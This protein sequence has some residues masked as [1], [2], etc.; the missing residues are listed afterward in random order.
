MEE[1]KSNLWN[2]IVNKS[3][4]LLNRF[5]TFDKSS[6]AEGSQY[7][8]VI[9]DDKTNAFFDNGVPMFVVSYDGEK[10]LGEIGPIKDYRPNYV[11][12]RMRSWQAYHESDIAQTVL[13]KHTIWII[14]S[15]LKLQADPVKKVLE[16]EN[17]DLDTEEF[18]E[19]AEARFRTYAYSRC[20]DYSNMSNLQM[21]ANE[22][23]KNCVIGGDVL[24]ILRYIENEIKFQLIDGANV[25]SPFGIDEL[26]LI[27][28]RGNTIKHGIEL[29]P[30]GTHVAYYVRKAGTFID[31]ERV[32]ARGDSYGRMMAYMVYGSKYR[33]DYHR[34]MPLISVIL[35]TIKKLER[36]K[37]ATIGSAEERQKIVYSIEH[38]RDSNGENPLNRQLS[39]SFDYN[40]GNLNSDL[41][42]TI[43][44]NNLANTIS[45]SVNK[46]TYNMPI[47]SQLKALE[48]KNELYFK[49]FYTININLVCSAI[50]IPP[51]VA[52]SKYD[53]N[54]SASRA[55]LKDWENTI[56]VTRKNFAFQFY[57]PF[58]NLWLETEI[59][60]NK[61][62]APGYLKA[63]LF[64]NNMVIDAYQNARFVGTGVPHIDPLKEVKAEREKLGALGI[65]LPLTT[66][67]AATEALNGGDSDGNV[68]QFVEELNHAEGLGLK[69]KEPVLPAGI[70]SAGE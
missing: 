35:E 59:L 45:A 40:N 7:P 2:W 25:V 60:K 31:V 61:I 44:G 53:S 57:Q 58:Y 51:E 42:R 63:I 14:G 29:S 27:R 64:K 13:N 67:E 69:E 34:G 37:E 62:Q 17:I 18:N 33:L 41:P 38:T 11:A 36:Y 28:S 48:S 26:G 3:N 30:E 65:N 15:G 21:G 54:F 24:V 39:K 56:N 52:L 8:K 20:S 22:A 32:P 19:M 10:N 49:D 16:S 12:L 55:A 68:M 46:Q 5:A 6:V 47:G 50:G 23:F 43:E 66:L 1:S 70:G 9:R 4:S